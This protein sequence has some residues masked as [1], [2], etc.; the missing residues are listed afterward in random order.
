MVPGDFSSA[1]FWLAAA[2]AMPGARVTIRDV[3]LN[4]R[5]TALLDVLKRMGAD[6]TVTPADQ[7]LSSDPCGE[8][9]VTGGKLRGT[10]V[11]GA[12]IPNLI[13]ELPIAAVAGAL[14]DGITEIRDARELRVKESDRIACVATNLKALGIA[15][16]EYD[17]G[18]VI[19]G[20]SPIRGGVS[21]SSYGDH[22]IAMAMAILALFAD[23]PV[24]ITPVACVDTSYPGFWNHLEELGGHVDLH[25]CH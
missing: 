15:V 18:L 5:R 11:G 7:L 23:S 2:A 21:L 4:P 22:R 9:A 25:H 12:E 24:T 14:A 20:G 16:T 8:V 13:D 10:R 19:Q 6:I 1:A 17:D 3:G